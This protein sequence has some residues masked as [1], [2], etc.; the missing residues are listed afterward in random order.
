MILRLMFDKPDPETALE[1][2]EKAR[3]QEDLL[4]VLELVVSPFARAIYKAD[5]DYETKAEAIFNLGRFVEDF[6]FLN[7]FYPTIIQIRVPDFDEESLFKFMKNRLVALIHLYAD[8][9]NG[10]PLEY[11]SDRLNGE[12]NFMDAP[13]QRCNIYVR[14]TFKDLLEERQKIAA[15]V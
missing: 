3:N 13:I 7:R 4:N 11:V 15:D 9:L 6:H 12:A 2:T 10:K 5:A 14:T 1:L 8:L